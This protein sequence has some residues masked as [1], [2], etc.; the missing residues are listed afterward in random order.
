MSKNENQKLYCFFFSFWLLTQVCQ[1][2]NGSNQKV[3]FKKRLL[4]YPKVKMTGREMPIPFADA[5]FMKL[6]FFSKFLEDI[7]PFRG[8]TDTPLLD[9]WWHLPWV[10]MPGWIPFCMLSHLCDPQIHLWCDTCW[11]YRG[12]HGSWAF[13]IPVLADRGVHK[14]LWRFGQRLKAMTTCGASTGLYT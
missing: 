2:D 5:F 11:L 4:F 8:A 6:F 1:G 14:H 10:S 3:N 7:S 9:F 12:Q 13:L